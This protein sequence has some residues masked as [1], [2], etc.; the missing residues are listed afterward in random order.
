MRGT[1]RSI[2]TFL[3]GVIV[4]VWLLTAF[5]PVILFSV[6]TMTTSTPTPLAEELPLSPPAASPT[7][8]DDFSD[9]DAPHLFAQ[10]RRFRRVTLLRITD[11]LHLAQERLRGF[12]G[13]HRA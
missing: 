9:L 12:Q 7:V 3:I 10:A 1:T 2:L 6:P 5:G 4:G 11:R 13:G 8:I